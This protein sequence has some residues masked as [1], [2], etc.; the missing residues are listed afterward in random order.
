MNSSDVAENEIIVTLPEEH[1]DN[2]KLAAL[3]CDQGALVG[4][5]RGSAFPISGP[6]FPSLPV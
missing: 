3:K 2:R 1:A 5:V 4:A 6:A